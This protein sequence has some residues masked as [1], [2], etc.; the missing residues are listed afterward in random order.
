MRGKEKRQGDFISD[1]VYSL[2][3]KNHFFRRLRELLD[4]EAL[5][6]GLDDCYRDAGRP[7]VPPEVMLRIM[8]LQFL[9]DRSDR[10]IEDDLLMHA[11][12]KLFA[13]LAADERGPDHSTLSRFRDRVGAAR[14]AAL[15]NKVVEAAR[16][17]GIV[18][19]RLHAIDARAVRANA[20]T[21]KR[22]DRSVEGDDDEDPPTGFVK[23]EGGAPQGSP[24]ADAAWG[25]K[26]RNNS[27]Y[28]YKHH[29]SVDADSGIITESV[30]KPGNEHDGVVMG[31]VL[32][33]R[34]EAVVA[35]KAYDLPR[36]HLL[37]RAKGIV[38]RIIKRR[39]DN[40]S[41]NSGRWVVKRTNA[42]VKRWCDGG[43]ARYWGLEKVSIQMLLA[44]MAANLKRWL[45]MTAPA[46][47][48]TG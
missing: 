26:S 20:A 19:D 47:S 25:N 16:E 31:R 46:V 48:A 27:F 8:L 18:G 7:S 42:I 21:W 6:A 34:A 2:I 10:Q 37:L 17:A 3:P 33:G 5:A 14:F 15:F 22:V 35:D 13:G 36:N 29:I 45:G 4:W 32:D 40:G 9:V 11:G 12:Y 43:R 1:S 44:S 30:V 28:G 41:N 39:G 38:N 24:D 23:F